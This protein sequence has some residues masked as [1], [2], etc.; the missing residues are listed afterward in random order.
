MFENLS[1]ERKLVIKRL[2]KLHVVYDEKD[3]I[4]RCVGRQKYLFDHQGKKPPILLPP[5]HYLMWLI[6][7]EIHE[8]KAGQLGSQGTIAA[9]R[10]DYWLPKATQL[11]NKFVARCVIC[12][13]KNARAFKEAPCTLPIPPSIVPRVSG[14]LV[15]GSGRDRR[16]VVRRIWVILKMIS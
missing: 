3:R 8:A 5:D 4:L 1:R 10:S 6:V 9:I 2:R 7:R 11:L 12:Q 16:T 15:G 13:K 14:R